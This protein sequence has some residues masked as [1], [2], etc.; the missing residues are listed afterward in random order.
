[1]KEEFLHYLWKYRL[2]NP[3]KLVD[4]HGNKIIVVHP[5]EYNRDSGP[6]FFNSRIAIDGTIWAGNI[7]IHSKSSHFDLHGHQ[8]DPAFNNV[9]LHLVNEYDKRVFSEMG[10]ELLT[11]ELKFDSALYEKYI[12]LINFPFV[13]ACQDEINKLDKI[14]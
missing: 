5:G 3:D 12:S 4:N 1:M 9:I 6:D 7:E 2:Y 10:E 13:I 14:L 8:T 11:I